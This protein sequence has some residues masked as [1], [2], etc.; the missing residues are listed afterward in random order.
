V[1]DPCSLLTGIK[2]RSSYTW[3][4]LKDHVRPAASHVGHVSVYANGRAAIVVR[5][6]DEAVRC[7]GETYRLF[8]GRQILTRPAEHLSMTP[9]D[10][11]QLYV[12][13]WETTPSCAPRLIWKS[14][15][16]FPV[17]NNTSTKTAYPY[18]LPPPVMPTQQDTLAQQMASLSMAQKQLS[19]AY[20]HAYQAC[21]L[22]QNGI[23]QVM[24]HPTAIPTAAYYMRVVPQ[25]Q[26]PRTV[27]A[28]SKAA[29]TAVSRAPRYATGPSSA[30]TTV[31]RGAVR[32]EY[33]GVFVSNLSYDVQDKDL[34]KLF[35]TYGEI[36][37]IDHKREVKTN[38]RGKSI[39]RSRGNAF[40]TFASS[41]QAK[42]AINELNGYVWD[43]RS[44]VV[45]FDTEA[46]PVDVPSRKSKRC[47][48]DG[49]PL[50]VDGSTCSD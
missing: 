6:L 9:L 22:P 1:N 34:Q 50:I 8:E 30:Q 18:Q 36:T 5:K 31:S 24:P 45:R 27:A 11:R 38:S 15:E 26:L 37:N 21:S 32:T 33:R 7:F 40:V 28:Y 47:T 13:L 49:G 10:G 43:D 12:E 4:D 39:S 41:E 29:P 14:M 20:Q 35:S 23:Q 3:Q 2:V 19:P 16:K 42:K 44:L 46:T 25:Q 48:T 17:A